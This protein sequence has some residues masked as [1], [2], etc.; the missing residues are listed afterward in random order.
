[1]RPFDPPLRW[2]NWAFDFRKHLRWDRFAGYRKLYFLHFCFGVISAIA[3]PVNV[4]H[5]RMIVGIVPE[6]LGR[7]CV[8]TVSSGEVLIGN[9]IKR[10]NV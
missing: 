6:K 8:A 2:W 4:S 10:E 1:M 3:L 7:A 5:S 9:F